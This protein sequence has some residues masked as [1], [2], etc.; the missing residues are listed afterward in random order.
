MHPATAV[1]YLKVSLMSTSYK[2]NLDISEDDV[3]R[4][5]DILSEL[6]EAGV[7]YSDL[8]SEMP[9]GSGWNAGSLRQFAHR[10]G[11]PRVNEKTIALVKAASR[12][13]QRVGVAGLYKHAD[14]SLIRRASA[15][16]ENSPGAALS[17][18]KDQI[19]KTLKSFSASSTAIDL[20][21]FMCFAR[22]GRADQ[23]PRKII[24]IVL[25]IK[26]TS[27]GYIFSMKITGPSGNRRLVIGDVS[28]T[29]SNLYF[30]G[31]AY[32]IRG[33]VDDAA[34][35]AID[36]LSFTTVREKC[37]NNEVGIEFLG[38]SN[39][40]LSHGTAPCHFTGLDGLSFP[41]SGIGC[42]ISEDLFEHYGIIRE[43]PS[44]VQCEAHNQ[45]L[46]KLLASVGCVTA[47]SS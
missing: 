30:S 45:E 7:T 38:V 31:I 42:L 16:A 14:Q 27:S 25:S 15:M 6:Q 3:I 10:S 20:P 11:K 12:L 1:V 40:Y 18:S 19:S 23:K 39:N 4:V 17:A 33:I 46:D 22:Y 29:T 5:K 34:F 24:L 9:D 37:F 43:V 21:E 41:V 13:S 26:A 32:S 47:T 8:V 28:L 44:S 36:G 35:S 2:Y